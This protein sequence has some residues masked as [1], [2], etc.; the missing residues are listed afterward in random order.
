MQLQLSQK[1][2]LLLED[3]KL[4]EE[5]CVIKYQNYAGQ[6]QDPQLKQLFNTLATDEQHH[7]GMINQMLQGQQPNMSHHSPDSLS[8]PSIS[9]IK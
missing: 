3:N 8:P 1:E 5:V 4:Q 6:A 7:F 2:R 9:T